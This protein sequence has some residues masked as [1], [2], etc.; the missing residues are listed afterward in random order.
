MEHTPSIVSSLLKCR[1]ERFEADG[2]IKER[3]QY[4]EYFLS[5]M[6]SLEINRL[7]VLNCGSVF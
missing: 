6:R 2:P 4:L 1:V 3:V 5:D 7:I